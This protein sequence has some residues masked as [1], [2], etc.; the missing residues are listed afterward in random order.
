METP[1][2]RFNHSRY[3]AQINKIYETER[4]TKEHDK[5]LKT[6]NVEYNRWDHH[7]K[8]A[9]DVTLENTAVSHYLCQKWKFMDR[10][11][12]D[13]FANGGKITIITYSKVNSQK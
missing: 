11:K 1:F 6:T 3:D 12:K 4:F 13:V 8:V 7:F 5:L 2:T 9:A 10:G